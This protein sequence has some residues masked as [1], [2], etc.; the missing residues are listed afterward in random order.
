MKLYILSL[1]TA[2]L[3]ILGS[4]QTETE[5]PVQKKIEGKTGVEGGDAT[6]QEIDTLDKKMDELM[7]GV[8]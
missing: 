6:S 4:C 8:Q 5:K 1:V 7:Q 2:S 3:V